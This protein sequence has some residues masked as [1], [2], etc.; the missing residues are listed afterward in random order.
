MGTGRFD[1]Q[2]GWMI[3]R[4]SRVALGLSVV[5]VVGCGGADTASDTTRI[6]ASDTAP[7]GDSAAATS[8]MEAA[9]ITIVEA[10]DEVAAEPDAT[11]SCELV[12][13]DDVEAATGLTVV[14]VEGDRAFPPEGCVFGFGLSADL[15]VETGDRAQFLFTNYMDLVDDGSAELIADLGVAAVYAGGF[16]GL[17]ID[18]GEGRFVSLILDGGYPDQ[19]AEPRDLMVALARAAV[20]N[21]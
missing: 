10:A 19:L 1:R 6:T 4:N 13:T 3:M 2:N 9:D 20:T 21:L 17:A 7:A 16:R 5:L 15:W 18:A 12:T 11:D 8:D 14:S